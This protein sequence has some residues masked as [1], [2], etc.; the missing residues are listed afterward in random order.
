M[1]EQRSVSEYISNRRRKKKGS[2]LTFAIDFHERAYELRKRRVVLR[3]FERGEYSIYTGV[4]FRQVSIVPR[5]V[6]SPS[7]YD[8]L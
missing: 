7:I 2:H 6:I 4:G 3:C 8:V 5:H 1:P